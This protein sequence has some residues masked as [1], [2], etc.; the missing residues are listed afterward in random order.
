ML[1]NLNSKDFSAKELIANHLKSYLNS[2]WKK[3][4]YLSSVNISNRTCNNGIET[5]PRKQSF[6]VSISNNIYRSSR[7]NCIASIF[8]YQKPL[9]SLLKE[10]KAMELFESCDDGIHW[11]KIG[12]GPFFAMPQSRSKS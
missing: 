6:S 2:S 7:Q 1:L 4:V 10:A 3:Q 9:I 11:F 8:A 12:F 5:K